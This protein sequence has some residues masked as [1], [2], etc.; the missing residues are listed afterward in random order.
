[1]NKKIFK[2][3][4]CFLFVAVAGLAVACTPSESRLIIG[5]RTEYVRTY[6]NDQQ[7]TFQN[8]KNFEVKF[9]TEESGI[10]MFNAT[11]EASVITAQQAEIINCTC[12]PEGQKYV[13]LFL[14]LEPEQVISYVWLAHPTDMLD[15]QDLFWFTARTDA[16]KKGLSP[17]RVTFE[18]AEKPYLKF[19]SIQGKVCV[20]DF[21]YYFI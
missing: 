2:I 1:M 19:D 17:F 20:V 5:D 16:N 8:T 14:D 6:E 10:H 21:T 13:V 18:D 9:L 3:A 12:Y 15:G 4:S 11:G 7:V